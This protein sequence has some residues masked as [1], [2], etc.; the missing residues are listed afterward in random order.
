[1]S[2]NSQSQNAVTAQ[3]MI[4]I[5]V[6]LSVSLS[7]R[8]KVFDGSSFLWEF[9]LRCFLFKSGRKYDAPS[10]IL[11]TFYYK[12][13]KILD[14]IIVY[15]MS[16]NR[17]VVSLSE[18]ASFKHTTE[19]ITCDRVVHCPLWGGTW[20]KV[21]LLWPRFAELFQDCLIFS[22]QLYWKYSQISNQTDMLL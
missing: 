16:G 17:R 10:T 21:G 1:M 18:L 3:I 22:L 4:W 2:P 9:Y 13:F 12:G 14:F 8:Q 19:Y 20:K 7:V 15:K 6:W 5:G 11:K